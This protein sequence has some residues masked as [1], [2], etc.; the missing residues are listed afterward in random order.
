MVA[1]VVMAV[2]LIRLVRRKTM[3]PE[4]T[5]DDRYLTAEWDEEGA[6]FA[7]V[8]VSVFAIFVAVL[9]GSRLSGVVAALLNPEYWALRQ[10]L[11]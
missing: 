9:V 8:G 4:K 1:W 5:E 11:K 2:F 3:A 6:V 10:I 7:W